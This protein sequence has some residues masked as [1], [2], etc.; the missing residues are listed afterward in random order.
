MSS[1]IGTTLSYLQAFADQAI[2][3]ASNHAN[4]AKTWNLNTPNI[5]FNFSTTKPTLQQP[6]MIGSILDVGAQD[7][8]IGRFNIEAE[9]WFKK[10]FP[11]LSSVLKDEPEKWVLGIMNGSKPLADAQAAVELT[12]Q[13]G[14][15]RA[16][17]QAT[18]EKAQIAADFSLR[19]FGVPPGA[20]L[21]ATAAAN[22]RA[23]DAVAELNRQEAIKQAE[24][25][26]ELSKF[27]QTTA[28]QLKTALYSLCAGFFS[29][30]A[31]LSAKDPSSE[32]MRAKA[33]AYSSYISGLSSFYNVELG[34][35]QL[36]LSG[37]KTKAEIDKY[38]A[39]IKLE[40]TSKGID[41]Y[42]TAAATAAKGFSE[43]AAAAANAQSALQAEL[44]S[45]SIS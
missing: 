5:P 6:P 34:F 3:Q 23:S 42:N 37:L 45:G 11:N 8:D 13:Q 17:R 25:A 39:D 36:K 31:D 21:A 26:V 38:N 44:F 14:R 33:Q 20:M 10:F 43:A 35:E 30:I 28:V 24:L 22:E 9:K 4:R 18:S 7:V 32:K 29:T 12:W 27:A 41:S 16:T 19:G 1:N 2:S 15:D 40:A